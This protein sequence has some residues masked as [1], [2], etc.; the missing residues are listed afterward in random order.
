MDHPEGTHLN[1]FNPRVH[2]RLLPF[3][4]GT[5][6][7]GAWATTGV[8][9]RQPCRPVSAM[10]PATRTGS[11]SL[12]APGRTTPISKKLSA[13]RTGSELG[14]WLKMR[15]DSPGYGHNVPLRRR[16]SRGRRPRVHGNRIGRQD[17]HYANRGFT[18]PVRL[19]SKAA[20]AEELQRAPDW[21]EQSE[22]DRAKIRASLWI[23]RPVPSSMPC[24]RTGNFAKSVAR[25]CTVDR[26]LVLFQGPFLDSIGQFSKPD[27][28]GG[29]QQLSFR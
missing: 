22:R 7:A 26:A 15:N 28:K 2:R 16:S 17:A 6:Q 21:L 19:P 14:R 11:W 5:C 23:G 20:D 9:S 25:T 1:E 27:G 29:R 3:L 13:K 4:E 24:D 12:R 18:R 10:S 8:S